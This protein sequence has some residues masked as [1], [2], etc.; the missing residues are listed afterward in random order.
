MEI[1]RLKG[2]VRSEKNLRMQTEKVVE[3]KFV[4]FQRLVEEEETVIE[5]LKAKL[6]RYEAEKEKLKSKLS[7]K[8]VAYSEDC[9]DIPTEY[10]ELYTEIKNLLDP[11]DGRL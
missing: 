4:E 1:N 2:K 10:L 9:N 5:K 11:E 3:E 7:A 8:E 6:S